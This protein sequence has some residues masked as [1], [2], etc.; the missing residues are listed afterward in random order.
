MSPCIFLY[1]VIFSVQHVGV[2][3]LGYEQLENGT[4]RIDSVSM[5]DSG[6]YVCVAQ[7]SAGT[8]MAQ[9]RLQVQGQATLCFCMVVIFNLILPVINS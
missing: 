4:L 8:A 2:Y 3:C 6:I 5:R 7:N 9:V 1:I